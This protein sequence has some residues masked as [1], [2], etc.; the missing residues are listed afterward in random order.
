[1]GLYEAGYRETGLR[2]GGRY[3]TLHT[4]ATNEPIGDLSSSPPGELV[5]VPRIFLP[6]EKKISG[7][8]FRAKNEKKMDLTNLWKILRVETEGG[9]RE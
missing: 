9:D 6:I 4:F 2:G 5:E 8:I 1:M 3:V 7:S